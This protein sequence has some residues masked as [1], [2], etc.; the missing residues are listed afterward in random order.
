MVAAVIAES[1]RAAVSRLI[2]RAVSRGLS[3]WRRMDFTDLDRAWLDVGP[4]VVAAAVA[5]QALAV[6]S[7]GRYA[8]QAERVQGRTSEAVRVNSAALA[9][10]DGSGR[11]IDSLMRGSVVS[12]KRAVGAGLGQAEAM[13]AGASY[14]AAMMK[15]AIA[16]VARS[17]DAVAAA[18]KGFTK[19]VRVVQAGACSRCAILAGS[20]SAKVAFQRHP[21]CRCTAFPTFVDAPA[22]L[23]TSAE[24]YFESLDREEQDRVFTKGGA[25]AIR[26]GARIST[27][28]SARRGATGISFSNRLDDRLGRGAWRRMQRTTVGYRPDGS[29]IQ[30]FTTTEGTTRRGVFGRMQRD[31]QRPAGERYTRSTRLR[32]MPESIVQLT[33]DI[34]LRQVL[35]RDAGYLDFPVQNY[36]SNAWLAE[37]QTQRAIDRQIADD[38]YRSLGITI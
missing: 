30:V 38:F 9:G 2:D 8:G 25:E 20:Y 21:A 23:F 22:G 33:D 29:P 34:E 16:D 24:D 3:A 15:T 12:T 31:F 14:L 18:G 28:V 13:L 32:L 27:V 26:S 19:Y 10:V 37:R 5:A 35:L 17:G 6:E 36:S 7:S 4:E 11:D 1:H